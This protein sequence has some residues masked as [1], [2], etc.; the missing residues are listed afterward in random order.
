M[1]LAKLR[2]LGK[3]IEYILLHQPDEF[4]LF[5]DSD[6]SVPIKELMWA[7]HEESEWRF[8][9]RNHL[10]ELAHSGL[11]FAFEVGE[12]HIRPKS[13]PASRA[14]SAE[15]PRVL[16]YAAR[17]KAYPI[18]IKQGLRP[19][20]R[21]HVPLA[22]T[23]ELALRIGRRRDPKPVLVT[24][25]AARAYDAGHEF[26]SCGELLY[27]VQQ[28]PADFLSGPP[29]GQQSPDRVPPTKTPS[30][31]QQNSVQIPGSFLLDPSKD[32]DSGRRRLRKKEDKWKRRLRRLRRQGKGQ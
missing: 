32:P 30:T 10:R 2:T 11:D 7:L 3:T 28:L 22:T 24:V 6:G 25:H 21:A 20:N 1:A 13:R 29:P 14:R 18:I 17:R 23:G 19:T 9:R 5:P 31:R 16:F 8:V 26:V 27:L 4:G 15:P 12:T